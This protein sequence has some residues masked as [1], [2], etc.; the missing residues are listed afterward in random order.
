MLARLLEVAATKMKIKCILQ[1]SKMCNIYSHH[2]SLPGASCHLTVVTMVGVFVTMALCMN[3]VGSQL[4]LLL[5]MGWNLV[6]A[7]VRSDLE[8]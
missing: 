6:L 5:I 2:G 4:L 8:V 3:K 7:S 1:Y